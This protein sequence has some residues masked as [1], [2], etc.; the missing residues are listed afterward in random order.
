MQAVYRS[1]QSQKVAIEK[2]ASIK[3][4][5]HLQKFKY[6]IKEINVKLKFL[7]KSQP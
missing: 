1:L 3:V 5:F 7:I 2:Y 6:L 4:Y